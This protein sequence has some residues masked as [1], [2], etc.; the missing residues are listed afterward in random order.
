M[1]T[2]RSTTAS[3]SRD[4]GLFSTWVA[5]FS[6]EDDDV[7]AAVVALNIA[8]CDY[9]SGD[10]THDEW[11]EFAGNIEWHIFYNGM[12]KFAEA[13]DNNTLDMGNSSND[14]AGCLLFGSATG[15]SNTHF[16]N[17]AYVSH[18]D[19][20]CISGDYRFYPSNS[21]GIGLPQI[22]GSIDP[23]E[24]FREEGDGHF[25]DGVTSV[26]ESLTG[27]C[28]HR[29][30]SV[31]GVPEN[32]ILA[33]YFAVA[34]FESI[35]ADANR[36][37]GQV[38]SDNSL[39][40]Y[41]RKSRII[42]AAKVM[43]KFWGETLSAGVNISMEHDHTTYKSGWLNERT[44]YYSY[45]YINYLI[46]KRSMVSLIDAISIYWGNNSFN[47]DPFTLNADAVANITTL[48]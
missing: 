19:N 45:P 12:Y 42:A 46:N 18:R 2:N 44:V 28:L 48:Q 15:Y 26:L 32:I 36:V 47:L 13:T 23:V 24:T 14:S 38:T 31:D 20:S 37:S 11:T 10:M 40:G 39:R 7:F 27:K 22:N 30:D 21:W 16:E 9:K 8:Y 25:N 33:P 3:I 41:D 43:R 17:Q 5:A 29:P 1:I 6:S 35:V 34:K 4:V